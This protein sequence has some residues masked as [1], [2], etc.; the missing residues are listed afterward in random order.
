MLGHR[1][2]FSL[3]YHNLFLLKKQNQYAQK[4]NCV[5]FFYNIY[6]FSHPFKRT[7]GCTT[8]ELK[9]IYNVKP[10]KLKLRLS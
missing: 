8:T 10:F 9:K 5:K 7:S 3:N 2:Q 4:F 6:I 1:I